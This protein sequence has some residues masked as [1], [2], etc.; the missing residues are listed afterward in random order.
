[1]AA[2]LLVLSGKFG[3]LKFEQIRTHVKVASEFSNELVQ[4]IANA[5]ELVWFTPVHLRENLAGSN[6]CMIWCR[7]ELTEFSHPSTNQAQ[8]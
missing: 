4:T 5:R 1:M 3:E 8:H 2:V 7:I 6:S